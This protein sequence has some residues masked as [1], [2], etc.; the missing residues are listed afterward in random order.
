[1]NKDIEKDIAWLKKDFG[2]FRQDI[3][4]IIS[5]AGN[6][7][8][9]KFHETKE[10]LTTAL[11][12]FEGMAVDSAGRVNEY[13]HEKADHAIECSRDMVVRH[14]LTTVLV[15]FAVGAVTAFLLGKQNHE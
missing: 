12:D 7:S 10:K 14:P 5:D 11:H 13:A 3:N 15:S 9:D 2:K 6:F 4:S 8:Q 1:M